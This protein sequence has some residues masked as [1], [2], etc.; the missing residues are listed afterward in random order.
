MTYSIARPEFTAQLADAIIANANGLPG[1]YSVEQLLDP[2]VGY[3]LVVT[4]NHSGDVFT[5]VQVNT[6]YVV[7]EWSFGDG[8]ESPCQF[9]TRSASNFAHHL[10]EFMESHIDNRFEFAN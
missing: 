10:A 7:T 6:N 1:H 2:P 5:T 3:S 8:V 4:D 9:S